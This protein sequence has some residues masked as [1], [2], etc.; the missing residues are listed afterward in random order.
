VTD[1]LHD[2]LIEPIFGVEG[3]DGRSRVSLAGLLARLGRR[4][5]TEMT[6]LMPHQQ[7]PWHALVVQ[8]AALVLARSGDARLDRS[9]GEWRDALRALAGSA[10]AFALVVPDLAK[11][12][13]MQP[14]VPEGSLAEWN[15]LRTPDALDVLVTAKNHDVKMERFR[16]PEL[17]HWVFALVSLQTSEGYSGRDN[18]GV[19]RMNGGFSSRPCVA[20]AA[21]V[22]F[23]VR[24]SRDVATWLG[25]RDLL[26]DQHSYDAEGI[27]LLWIA[28]WDGL[29]SLAV[30][31]LDPFF[32]E[33]CRRVR[34]TTEDGALVMYSRATKVP[35]T[36]AKDLKG[37]TGDVWTPLK[38][39][40]EA[41]TVS[42]EGFGYKR[43]AELL[44]SADWQQ[45]PAQLVRAEDGHT[46]VLIARALVRGQGKTEG[47]HER[48]VPIPEKAKRFFASLEDR[49]EAGKLAAARVERVATMRNKVL[50]P[51]LLVI[52]QGGPKKP[53][54]EDE[55]ADVHID[56][57][58]Q[59]VDALFFAELFDALDLEVAEAEARWSAT[60]FELASDVK[61]RAE[62]AL[63]IPVARRFRALAAGDRAFIGSAIKQGFRRPSAD[64]VEG[65]DDSAST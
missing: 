54:F 1:A 44:F 13:F 41:L 38:K 28:P 65:S 62:R 30:N 25:E 29:Q 52:A 64:L 50:K 57:F 9:E 15:V 14:P 48:V 32:I 53:N 6:A 10:E 22:A 18:H 43:L 36:A 4:E 8:L 37:A 63:P 2:L 23:D 35:R 40:G 20:A 33:I 21:D 5:P 51:A 55:A 27:A 58:E 59:R 39:T 26:V 56:A 31:A 49:A 11:P 46:P 3:R 42:R 16:A 61:K 17:E 24:F 47:L 7:H 19:A 12:A 45:C 34:F 60:L